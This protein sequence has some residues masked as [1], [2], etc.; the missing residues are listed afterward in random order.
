MPCFHSHPYVSLPYPASKD[1][2]CTLKMTCMAADQG[3]HEIKRCIEL[4]LDSGM[5]MQTSSLLH[6]MAMIHRSTGSEAAKHADFSGVSKCPFS[7]TLL[8][9]ADCIADSSY[10]HVSDTCL[11]RLGKGA[12]RP[13]DASA[14]PPDMRFTVLT[15]AKAWPAG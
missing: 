9:T 10:V 13:Q 14:G 3:K 4:Y 1:I 5:S 11:L 15:R 8:R 6:V 2:V 7:D 12:A